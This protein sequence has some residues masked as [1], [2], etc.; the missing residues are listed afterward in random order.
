A[1]TQFP[2]VLEKNKLDYRPTDRPP[3]LSSCP[4]ARPTPELA[5]SRPLLSLLYYSRVNPLS[6]TSDDPHDIYNPQWATDLARSNRCAEQSQ[7]I[8]TATSSSV[9]IGDG[10]LGNIG[11]IIACGLSFFV[12]L[13]LILRASKRK[14]AVGLIEFRLFL[15][16]YALS[17]IFQIL[18]TGSFLRQAST[19]LVVLTAIHMGLIAA[20]GW[21]LISNGIVSM[22]WVEDGTISSL[23][24]FW[25]LTVAFFVATLYISLDTAF[26]W[27]SAFGPSNPPIAQ[28]NIP[29]FVLTSIWPGVAAVIYLIIMMVVVL[30]ILRERRP[31]G[32]YISAFLLFAVAQVIYFL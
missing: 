15:S 5:S 19:A 14:A 6:T 25:G 32:L 3:A 18:T 20:L 8:L 26:G 2:L 27:T 11:N 22:Q 24:P 13:A 16:M 9:R 17:L 1:P 30:R 12:V 31:V 28:K 21:A 23:A 29:L 4:S 7:A 10:R